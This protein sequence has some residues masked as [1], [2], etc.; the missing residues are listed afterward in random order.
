MVGA[1]ILKKK[2]H[3]KMKSKEVGPQYRKSGENAAFC[4]YF[5]KQFKKIKKKSN[6]KNS[7]KK[8]SGHV[9]N[10]KLTLFQLEIQY[11]LCT[12]TINFIEQVHFLSSFNQGIV[13]LY[14]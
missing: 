10:K 13:I 11:I 2:S 1:R 12:I 3:R 7:E 4:N 9:K 14:G 6:K 8:S 5:Q